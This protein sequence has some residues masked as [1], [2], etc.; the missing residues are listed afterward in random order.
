MSVEFLD[1]L[2]G[3]PSF[4]LSGYKGLGSVASRM[5]PL[6]NKNQAA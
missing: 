5:Y 6:F 1:W 3:I 4:Q 2:W